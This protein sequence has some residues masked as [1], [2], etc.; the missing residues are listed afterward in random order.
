MIIGNVGKDYSSA[1]DHLIDRRVFYNRQG[2]LCLQL[3][4][5]AM[6]FDPNFRTLLWTR[7][8]PAPFSPDAVAKTAAI[9]FSITKEQLIDELVHITLRSSPPCYLFWRHPPGLALP[10]LLSPRSF[11]RRFAQCPLSALCLLTPLPAPSP[12]PSLPRRPPLLHSRPPLFLP[13]A[14]SPERLFP[15][16][17]VSFPAPRPLPCVSPPAT[18]ATP[19]RSPPSSCLGDLL[20]CPYSCPFLFPSSPPGRCRFEN[21]DMDKERHDLRRTKARYNAALIDIEQGILNAIA[22]KDAVA[23]LESPVVHRMLSEAQEAATDLKTRLSKV[24]NMEKRISA[25][26]VQYE[27]GIAARAAILY[28]AVKDLANINYA[29][30]FSLRWFCEVWKPFIPPLPTSPHS[31]SKI[32]QSLAIFSRSLP[33][34]KLPL[35]H[36]PSPPRPS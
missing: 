17:S 36:R 8:T 32:D 1:V 9:N 30:Q 27:D 5:K 13:R 26:R 20:L 21:P 24:E 6:P 25:V 29:Y 11:I 19:C 31:P 4:D 34:L 28:F 23:I 12:R 7:R 33:S 18:S 22:S 15:L 10:R 16:V 35:P 3:G 14:S 2:H